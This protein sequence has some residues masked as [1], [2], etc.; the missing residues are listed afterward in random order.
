MNLPVTPNMMASHVYNGEKYG[1]DYKE[2]LA[3]SKTRYNSNYKDIIATSMGYTNTK[4]VEYVIDRTVDYVCID[5]KNV[6][7]HFPCSAKKVTVAESLYNYWFV[8]NYTAV[9]YVNKVRNA[10]GRNKFFRTQKRWYLEETNPDHVKI[11]K[12]EVTRTLN[13]KLRGTSYTDIHN[14]TPDEIYP[15]FDR[16]HHME[17]HE[18]SYC[19]SKFT[20]EEKQLCMIQFERTYDGKF[21]IAHW[22]VEYKELYDL[23]IDISKKKQDRTG[24]VLSQHYDKTY[25]ELPEEMKWCCNDLLWARDKIYA[26]KTRDNAL[27]SEC[28]RKLVE[29]D[30]L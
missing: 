16:F 11:Y 4:N 20:G 2:S 5:E 7:R 3:F 26:I 19:Y 23:Y 18:P 15:F 24:S 6:R 17:V 27:F 28:K 14:R 10:E 12:F 29:I 25:K 9:G 8:E 30:S 1:L 13:D 21:R 22:K